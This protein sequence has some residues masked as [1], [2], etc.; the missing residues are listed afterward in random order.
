M[1]VAPAALAAVEADERFVVRYVFYDPAGRRVAY[2]GALRD[3]YHKILA[4]FAVEFRA[5][6]VAAVLCDVFS[7]VSEIEQSILALIGL[8]NY[9]SALAA[10]AAVRSALGDVFFT[11][12]GHAAV[13]AVAGFY[14]DFY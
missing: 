7:A 4:V 10:V 9:V 14:I 3:L 13:A 5:G 2:D 12:E 1:F 8:K 6:S 11:P